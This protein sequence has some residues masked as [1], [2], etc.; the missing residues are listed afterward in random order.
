M[1]HSGYY[2]RIVDLA[3]S[4]RRERTSFDPPEDPPAVERATTY[5]REGVGPVVAL[6]VEARTAEWDV[7]FSAR[8]H[9]L[10]HRALNDYLTLYARCYG[11][12]VEPEATIRTAAELLIETHD[13]RDTA[14]MLTTVPAR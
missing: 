12:D 4:A 8:E 13:A 5:C 7:E 2:D 10:L 3:E 1:T 9:D 6:Y 14:Q 11:V